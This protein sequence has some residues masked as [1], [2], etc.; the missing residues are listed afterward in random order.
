MYTNQNY[1]TMRKGKI[2][3]DEELRSLDSMFPQFAQK[4]R[5]I[6]S[7]AGYY[8]EIVTAHQKTNA[9]HIEIQ[10]KDALLI[11]ALKAEVAALK[12]PTVTPTAAVEQVRQD[13]V[14]A[15]EDARTQL[16]DMLRDI[17]KCILDEV[18]ERLNNLENEV[19]G[20]LSDAVITI[21]DIEGEL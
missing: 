9:A 21:E 3:T 20:T 16:V 1:Q 6:Q 5:C 14:D 19:D 18:A 11:A 17:R 13:A 12:T 4:V 7:D 15:V 10:K 2:F 8:W